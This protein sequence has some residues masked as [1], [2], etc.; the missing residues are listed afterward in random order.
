VK[1]IYEEHDSKMG[2]RLEITKETETI[3]IL[4]RIEEFLE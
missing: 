4:S 3:D 1:K 2:N